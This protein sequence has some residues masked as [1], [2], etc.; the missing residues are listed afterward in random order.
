MIDAI[1]GGY[2]KCVCACVYTSKVQSCVFSQ[3]EQ[4]DAFILT[5]E[6]Q[7]R[8]TAIYVEDTN[9]DSFSGRASKRR[10][11]IWNG[12]VIPLPLISSQQ[13]LTNTHGNDCNNMPVIPVVMNAVL[14]H[15]AAHR[16]WAMTYIP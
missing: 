16:R 6:F 8:K 2:M 13:H 5:K 10:E 3:E 12:D 9:C 15:A 1:F 11:D 14:P 4:S 7:S